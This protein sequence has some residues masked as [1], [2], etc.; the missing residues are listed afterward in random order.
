[1]VF[2]IDYWLFYLQAL[3]KEEE[4]MAIN[5]RKLWSAHL[6][7]LHTALHNIIATLSVTSCHP[8]QQILRKICWQMSDLAAPTAS[9][10]TQ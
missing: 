3:L 7:P 10:I 2:E 4:Q 5:T 1:M 9:M 6:L 8:L